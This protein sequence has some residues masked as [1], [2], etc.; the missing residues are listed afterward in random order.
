[1]EHPGVPPCTSEQRSG[2]ACPAAGVRCD[3]FLFCNSLRVCAANELAVRCPISQRAAKEGIA[4][5]DADDARRVH[6]ELM[7][8]PLATWR[9]KDAPRDHRQLGFVIE[10]VSPSAGVAADGAHVDLYGYTSMVVAALQVQAREIARLHRRV[11]R[12]S[13]RL[14]HQDRAARGG[15]DAPPLSVPLRLR[16]ARGGH[17]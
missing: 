2:V 8:Y 3:P 7:R 17:G 16:A 1:V 11:D 9:Y 10:D 6:D 4:Y 13:R 12:L 14:A 15:D 5:L